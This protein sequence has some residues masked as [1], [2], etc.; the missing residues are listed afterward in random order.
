MVYYT[1]VNTINLAI[2]MDSSETIK[3]DIIA[4]INDKQQVTYNELKNLASSMEISEEML[5][6]A[7]GS[8]R[9]QTP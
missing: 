9:T 2:G 3:S 5:E 1:F 7:S 6:R 8:L 4:V